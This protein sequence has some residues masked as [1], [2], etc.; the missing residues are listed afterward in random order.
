MANDPKAKDSKPAGE[1]A[2][3]TAAIANL[4]GDLTNYNSFLTALNTATSA[5]SWSN[6]LQAYAFSRALDSATGGGVAFIKVHST[7]VG[8]ITKSN[9]WTNLDLEPPMYISVG[10]VVSFVFYDTQTATSSGSLPGAQLAP[11]TL[12]PTRAGLF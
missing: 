11:L 6:V 10:M 9:L 8:V 4:T 5:S 3:L 7:A 12:I 2:Q 1:I